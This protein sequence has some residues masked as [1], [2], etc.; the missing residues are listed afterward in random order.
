MPEIETKSKNQQNRKKLV[1]FIIKC[2]KRYI[3]LFRIYFFYPKRRNFVG[4]D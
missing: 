1:S 4:G 3:K 2:E